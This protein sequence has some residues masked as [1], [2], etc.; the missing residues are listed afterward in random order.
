MANDDIPFNQWTAIPNQWLEEITL[1]SSDLTAEQKVLICLLREILGWENSR[2][3][4]RAHVGFRTIIEKT[5]VSRQSVINSV[6]SLETQGLIEVDREGRSK[7]KASIYSF[8]FDLVQRYQLN[9]VQRKKNKSTKVNRKPSTTNSKKGSTTQENNN[10]ITP[11]EG[12]TI[13]ECEE[14]Q[15][16]TIDTTGKT[17]GS[18]I[19]TRGKTHTK[20][21][22]KESFLKKE[23][24]PDNVSFEKPLSTPPQGNVSIKDKGN[25]STSKT[26]CSRCK[27]PASDD[28][29]IKHTELGVPI[30]DNCEQNQDSTTAGLK[31][32]K[33]SAEI[34][35]PANNIIDRIAEDV[36]DYLSEHGESH[37]REIVDATRYANSAVHAMFKEYPNLFTQNPDNKKWRMLSEEEEWERRNTIQEVERFIQSASTDTA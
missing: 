34:K 31:E 23:P 20:K 26:V 35:S 36:A 8:N 24:P 1:H 12:S 19:A 21:L 30:C 5:G 28:N 33:P 4:N 13:A 14:N 22:I 6:K 17:R 18:T 11:A 3:S 32:P 9:L 37:M 10:N 7:G 15:G 16:S 25:E 29:H 27:Q 2:K